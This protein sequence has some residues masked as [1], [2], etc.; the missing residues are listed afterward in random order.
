MVK[1]RYIVSSEKKE[2]VEMVP[3]RIQLHDEKN[4]RT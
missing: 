4:I 1:K 3:G 2:P